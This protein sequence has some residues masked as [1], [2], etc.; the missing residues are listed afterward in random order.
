M[1]DRTAATPVCVAPT[2][3]WTGEGA[4]WDAEGQAVWWV[5]INRF[6]I[7]RLDAAGGGVRTWFFAE[8]PTAIALTD[9]PGTFVVALASRV[10]LWQPANDARSDF[11]RP[12]IDHPRVRSN[13][14][15]ADPAGNFWLG[16]MQNNVAPDGSDIAITDD[17]L[18][19][20]YRIAPDGSWTTAKIGI[21]IANTVAWSPDGRRFYFA[22]T[23]R[24]VIG[25]WDYDAA[26]GTIANERPFFT[27]FERGSPDGSAM[28]SAGYLWNA[29]YGGSCVVRIAPDG[30]VDRIVEM[31][32]AAPTTCT[33]GGP[34][35]KT[36]YITSAGGGSAMARGERLGGGLFALAVDAP[37]LPENRVR[38]G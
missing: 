35:L 18:G 17:T 15:R 38:L 10:I 25:V 9:R 1:S 12:D 22:D 28:D 16:T 29:R 37:G 14:A 20:L 19:R 11:A 33:F 8:P 27:G 4:L 34:D 7:H 30:S 31:P 6:L 5:D 26:T 13:D 23:L 3:D 24:N 2:G 32:V 21:G 36:L